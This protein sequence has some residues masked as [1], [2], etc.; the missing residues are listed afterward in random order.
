MVSLRKLWRKMKKEKKM[1]LQYDIDS[2]SKNFDDGYST[3]PDNAS[4]SFRARFAII[5]S[6]VYS[7]KSCEVS[8][9]DDNSSEM[10]C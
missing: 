2:Y 8:S 5:D 1:L 7:D 3:D 6:K 10:S 9:D 4:R